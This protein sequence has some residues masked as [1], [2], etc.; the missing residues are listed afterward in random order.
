MAGAQQ[1]GE[2]PELFPGLPQELALLIFAC[3]P[4]QAH[5][6]MKL[7]CRAWLH[8]VRGERLHKLRAQ[9]KRVDLLYQM[10]AD[11]QGL[12]CFV[13]GEN[14]WHTLPL[15]PPGTRQHHNSEDSPLGSWGGEP[16]LLAVGHKIFILD[17][18]G[19]ETYHGQFLVTFH[20]KKYSK[21]Y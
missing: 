10:R 11:N 7:V 20:L 19:F 4:R 14:K 12:L 21:L 3:V 2:K 13:P 8:E 15:P 18:G 16:I 9:L 17:S 1:S 5:N 6:E